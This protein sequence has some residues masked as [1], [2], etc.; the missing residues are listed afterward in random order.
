MELWINQAKKK[1][2]VQWRNKP[3]A[4]LLTNARA[5]KGYFRL[6]ASFK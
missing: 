5:R 6:A 3:A 2:E 1:K 4:I